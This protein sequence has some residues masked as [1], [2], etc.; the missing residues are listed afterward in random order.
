MFYNLYTRKRKITIRNKKFKVN[1]GL[2]YLKLDNKVELKVSFDN[3]LLT[4]FR[5]KDLAQNEA[6]KRI[7]S[8]NSFLH[9][10]SSR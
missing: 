3:S 4:T 6:T 7:D 9:I 8:K 2:K 1:K 5:A 10:Y